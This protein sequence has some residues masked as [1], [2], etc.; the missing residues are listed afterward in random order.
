MT[1]VIDLDDPGAAT[2][3]VDALGAH[4]H[5]AV[6]GH[7]VEPEVVDA[8]RAATGT[9][10]GELK[11]DGGMTANNLLMQLLADSLDATVVR[12]AITETTCLGAAYAAG[13]A[14]GYWAGLD[15]L[16]ANW[17]RAGQWIPSIEPARRESEY[18]MWRKAVQ[19]TLDWIEP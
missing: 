10:V 2:G 11:V 18:R 1:P 4:G 17:R 9:D 7:G 8:M 16:R 3:L 6:F 13:L 12:P 19:R 5:A 14:V 15:E